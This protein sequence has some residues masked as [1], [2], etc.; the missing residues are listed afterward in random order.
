MKDFFELR[1]GYKSPEEAKSFEDGKKA[2]RAGKMRESVNVIGG[3]TKK[4][5]ELFMGTKGI[6]KMIALSKEN[7]NIEYTVKSDNYGGFK[8]HWLKNGKFAKKT[9]ANIDFDMTKNAVRGKPKG[10]TVND[11]IFSLS[12]VTKES[13]ELDEAKESGIDVARRI[14]KNKQHEKGV[15]MQTANFILQIYDK[16]NDQIKKKMETQDIKQLAQ[17]A[18]K[19][20]SKR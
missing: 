6:D 7:P 10:K 12:Y 3:T 17:M 11:T 15:D 2:T 19:I 5:G 8:P 13:V 18:M 20:L 9:V 1:E 14:V 4:G 16:V